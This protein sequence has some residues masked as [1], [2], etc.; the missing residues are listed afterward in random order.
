MSRLHWILLPCAVLMG[1][2]VAPAGSQPRSAA[3]PAAAP[4][5]RSAPAVGDGAPAGRYV[6]LHV[7]PQN[8]ENGGIE[9]WVLDSATGRTWYSRLP[10]ARNEGGAWLEKAPRI[11]G[12]TD[13]QR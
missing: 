4:P 3:P 12:A 9:I 13:A 8:A 10:A 1:V 6:C 11:P 7:N 2:L 5:A